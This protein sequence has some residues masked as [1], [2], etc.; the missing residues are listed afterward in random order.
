VLADDATFTDP[1]EV[2]D[3]MVEAFAL[4][5]HAAGRPAEVTS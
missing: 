3:A 1:H 2:T 5:R 4:I